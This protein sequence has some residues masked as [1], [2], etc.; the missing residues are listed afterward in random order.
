MSTESDTSLQMMY[1]LKRTGTKTARWVRPLIAAVALHGAVGQAA[2][3][4]TGPGASGKDRIVVPRPVADPI[5]GVNR[6]LWAVNE[7]ILKDFVNPSSK[8][9]RAVVPKPLR[10]A[11]G[12]LSSTI[13]FP[14]RLANNLLQGRWKGAGYE[15]TRF[16]VN[17][18]LGLGGLS[19]VAS[20]LKIPRSP[21]DFGQT[22][23]KWGW[24][25]GVY[26]MLPVFGPSNERDAVGLAADS[27]SSPLTYFSPYSYTTYGITYNIL[28]DKVG[29]LVRLSDSQADPYSTVR[30][31]STL[32]SAQR[33]PNLELDG[34]R[35]VVS[36]ETLGAA[37]NG[38]RHPEFFEKMR[39]QSVSIPGT[40]HR[41]KFSYWLQPK[42]APVAYIV[43]GL[44]S[45]RL[46][47]QSAAL[48]ETV[49]DQGF[50]A[51]IITSA[52]HPEFME[53]ASTTAVPG[54][55][56]VDGHDVHVALTE[57]HQR[58]SQ[59]HP[60]RMEK[61]VLMGYSM[62]AFHTL[63]VASQRQAGEK[64]LIGFD[65]YVAID[66]PVRL[67]HGIA[68]LDGFYQA[69]MAWPSA[70]RTLRLENT[71]LK[72]AMYLNDPNPPSGPLPFSGVESKFLVG[73]AF[74]LT[75]RD[76][77]YST[78]VRNNQGILKQPLGSLHRDPVYEEIFQFSY[79]DYLDRFV[80]PY[81]QKRGVDL[82]APGALEK[83]SDLRTYAGALAQNDDI[84]VLVNQNDFL[85]A[86]EDLEWLRATLPANH[87]TVFEHGG[88]LG[89]L[90]APE[91]QKQ[92]VADLAD[93]KPLPAVAK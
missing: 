64:P 89:N 63:Y 35:D 57:V 33:K 73:Y 62:G 11:I 54:Y 34:E 27:A 66:T 19:D 71:F 59:L 6:S 28:T 46:S 9:Y 21:A 25:P 3:D 88:H 68:Q 30:F 50:S 12:N 39:T 82:T 53:H 13:S 37:F 15:T 79:R 72:I 83:S 78:Q 40:G 29:D 22:F 10:T 45:H 20:E 61:R 84:R 32:S 31:V 43:P 65:R 17:S 70:E 4:T 60:N 41:L 56:P 42:A 80:I 77:I 69:P 75:L 67:V 76:L 81:Y 26:L 2:P 47:G 36:L 92:I 23:G 86:P 52:F 16:L 51:V 49:Y 48:A 87:L 14:S 5:E 74:R 24:K 44:G 18:S 85:L 90:G 8:V 93:L 38:P 91:V 55:L 7:A 58:L 1:S